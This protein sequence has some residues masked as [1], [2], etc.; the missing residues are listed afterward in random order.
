ME[1]EIRAMRRSD[2][3]AIA[4]CFASW[5]KKREQYERYF[6]A[7]RSGER[8]TLVAEARAQ[9]VG[10][11]NVVWQSAYEPFWR[12]GIPEIVDLNVVEEFQRRGIGTALITEAERIVAGAGKPVIGI[13]VGQ[14]P[15]YAAAQRLY[16]KLGY[17]YN[18]RGIR[19]DP[20]WGDALYLTKRLTKRH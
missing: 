3:D 8:V 6:E 10:Y 13:G 9:V 12:D 18:G 17:V 1:F 19:T 14:T 16:P 11:T 20:Q 4:E 2:I 15:D 7:N 5:N